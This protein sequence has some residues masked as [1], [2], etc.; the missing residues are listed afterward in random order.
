VTLPTTAAQL[1]HEIQTILK[2]AGGLA[3]AGE[4]LAER[5][6]EFEQLERELPTLREAQARARAD[7]EREADLARG[8]RAH[9]D[10]LRA[11]ITAAQAELDALKAPIADHL[12]RAA[13]LDARERDFEERKARFLAESGSILGVSPE[14]A[15]Q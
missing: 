6:T 9:L 14:E 11:Q 1:G 5:L 7:T 12:Q 2:A 3:R 4:D 8:A 13:A 15:I 10:A